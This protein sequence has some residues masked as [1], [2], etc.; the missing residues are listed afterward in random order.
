MVG[1][2]NW[3]EIE[4]HND[5]GY[6]DKDD[7]TAARWDEAA[8]GWNARGAKEA[9]FTRRQVALMDKITANDRVLDICC[10][11]GLLSV[12]MAEKAK[13]VTGLDFG[14]R[15]LDLFKENTQKAGALN[16]DTIQCNWNTSRPG[17][18][19]PK[20]DIAVARHSPAQAD[21]LKIS[22]AATK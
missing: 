3:R 21:I 11:P 9:D 15:M 8:D 5:W 7:A 16:T 22:L 17:I 13:W 19:F 20:Y 12:P 14:K 18:D 2:L 4:K 1:W 6:R 10:G